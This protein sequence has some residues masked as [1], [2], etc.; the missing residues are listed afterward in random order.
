MSATASRSFRALHHPGFRAFFAC[1]ALAMMADVIEHVISYWVIFQKF[2]SAALGGFAV[3]SHWL[4]FLTLSMYTGGLAD[5]F[6]PRRIIQA[7]MLLFIGVS[8]SWGLL[9]WSDHVHMWQACVLLVVHGLAGVLWSPSASIL[10]HDM[11]GPEDLPS[12]VRLAAT[13][14]YLGMLVGPWFG[15]LLL[16]ALGPVVG[17]FL[18]ALIYTPMLLWLI[19]APYGPKF[20]VGEVVRVRTVRGLHEVIATLRVIR[21]KPVLLSMTLLAAAASFFIGNSYQAQMPGFATDLGHGDAGIAYGALLGADALGAFTGGVV[22]ESRGLLAAR[23]ATA[24]L[25]A[26]LWCLALGG[27]ALTHSYPVVLVLLFIAGFSELSFASMAQALVQLNAPAD[28]RGH[29]IGVY[30]MAGLG[31]RMFSGF[32]VGL[33]G[34]VIGIHV[35]LALSCAAMLVSALALGRRFWH[36][37]AHGH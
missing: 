18:N 31:M 23:P 8:V 32:W 26:G 17:I 20:R 10:L 16:H 33:I 29:V 11:V 15:S 30:V 37:P 6:D 22:L 1:Q 34:S 12:A 3:I 5:R 7:G 35:S 28:L 24:C 36:A 14:R 21:D 4:P 19:R 13:A 25:L 9:F 27:F 2:H